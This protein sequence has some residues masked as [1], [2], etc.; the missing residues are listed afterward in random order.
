MLDI[1][2]FTH[3]PRLPG[4]SVTAAPLL[5]LGLAALAFTAV[6]LLGL[7]RRDIG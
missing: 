6:G 2:P 1:S 7:R 3:T 4:G 5:W